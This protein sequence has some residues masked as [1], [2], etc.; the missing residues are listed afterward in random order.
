[1]ADP[2]KIIIG[3][4]GIVGEDLIKTE[5]DTLAGYVVDSVMPKAV[6][7]P[8]NTREVSEVVKF[9]N[10]ENLA[11]IPWGSGSKMS[12][13]HPPKRF[14]LV[15]C[16]SRMNH[17]IDV[18]TSNLTIT[19]ESGVK[20]RD[21]QA[22]L[23]T[24][25]DRCYLPLKDLTTGT[26][27]VI[28]SDRSHSGCF[29]PIDPSCSNTAT[30]G[31]VVAANSAGPRRLLYNLPRDM[32]LG[33]K[34]VAPNG[35]IAGGGG[36]TVKNV[37]GYDISKLMVGSMGSLGILCEMTFKLLPLPEQMETLLISFDSFSEAA[38]LVNRIFETTL[39]PA[40]VE[41]MNSTTFTNLGVKDIPEFD[42]NKYVVVIALEAFQDAIT[43][44]ETE[45]SEMAESIGAK[46]QANIKDLANLRFW[47]AVSDLDPT[48]K[49]KFP[50]LIKAKLNYRI[51]EWRGIVE[52]VD[53][54][55]SQNN[56]EHATL[57]HAGSGICLINLFIDQNDNSSMDKAV[58][59]M[60]QLL[61]RSRE[62]GG[63]MIIQSAPTQVKKRLK[64]WGEVGSDFIVMKRL[65]DQLDP[66]RIMSP[67]R[68]VGGL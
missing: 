66:S 19:V 2:K 8:R 17:M 5:P 43:R 20:F 31:G 60:A 29:L 56:I 50:D 11:I 16:T 28:C 26:E 21:I 64:V 23:A 15:I 61:E 46:S 68:F 10:R 37:S 39:I 9:A 40:A 51:S 35:E 38:D 25:E 14:D 62:A 18:D 32:I 36:K 6:V 49:E 4:T 63:N 41:V 47:L 13:G 12:M 42:S 58:E 59:A 22:R 7:F 54:T 1:M 48:L 57:A 45:I 24:E 33:V 27:E 34:V 30:I 3:L 55:L 65:K 53:S 44:M 67:G 52:F